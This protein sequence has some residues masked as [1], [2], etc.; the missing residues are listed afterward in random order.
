[1]GGR[2]LALVFFLLLGGCAAPGLPTRPESVLPKGAGDTCYNLSYGFTCVPPRGFLIT[3]EG[4]G[5]GEIM[6][7]VKKS[8]TTS[9]EANLSLRVYPLH[10]ELKWLAKERV[11]S[12]L[13]KSSG[14]KTAEMKPSRVGT[15]EG[16]EIRAEREYATGPFRIRIFCFERDS[17]AFIAEFSTPAGRPESEADALDA[18]VGSIAFR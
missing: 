8:Y 11:L 12:P 1:V 4:P 6:T 17:Q 2:I 7:L 13:E 15:R 9:E 5:P 18:F 3:S 10:G 14:L 16:F